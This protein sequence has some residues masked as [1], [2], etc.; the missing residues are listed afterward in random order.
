MPENPFATFADIWPGAKLAVV[1]APAPLPLCPR[2]QKIRHPRRRNAERHMASLLL[3]G[4][5]LLDVYRCATCGD[6][7]VG[8]L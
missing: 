7:H 5:H 4:E 6:W 2:T 1:T 8:H 3:A